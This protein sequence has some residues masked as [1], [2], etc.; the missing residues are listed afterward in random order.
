MAT[1]TSLG[2]YRG[3]QPLRVWLNFASSWMNGRLEGLGFRSRNRACSRVWSANHEGTLMTGALMLTP[4]VEVVGVLSWSADGSGCC[5][6][7]YSFCPIRGAVAAKGWGAWTVIGMM[8]C[9]D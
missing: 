7:R 8:Q 1:V 9:S 3:N 4:V 2:S 5:D 6:C